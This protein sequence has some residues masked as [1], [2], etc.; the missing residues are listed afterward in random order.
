LIDTVWPGRRTTSS[1]SAV[2]GR[3]PRAAAPTGRR[4]LDAESRARV[5]RLVVVAHFKDTAA[6]V[7]VIADLAGR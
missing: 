4:R 5:S 6:G 2:R 1:P 7:R 3:C